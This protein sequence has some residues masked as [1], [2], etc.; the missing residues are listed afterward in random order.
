M[1]TLNEPILK[2]LHYY[3]TREGERVVVHCLDLD[4]VASGAE[5]G[6]AEERLNTAVVAQIAACYMGGNYPQLRFTAPEEYWEAF[7]AAK[8]LDSTKL[9]VEVPPVVLPVNRGIMASVKVYRAER[10]MVAA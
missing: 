3:F 5:M 9:E 7:R 4:L 1:P 10:E 8:Q 2:A 6:I